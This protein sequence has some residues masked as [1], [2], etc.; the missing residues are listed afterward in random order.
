ML[1][2]GGASSGDEAGCLSAGSAENIWGGAEM[3]IGGEESGEDW[4]P[5]M[6]QRREWSSGGRRGNGEKM[7]RAR[8]NCGAPVPNRG[9]RRG[10]RESKGEEERGLWG[11]L[12]RG[13]WR[14]E[15][16]GMVKQ[17]RM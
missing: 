4:V 10:I 14:G 16:H 15:A 12:F 5:A 7:G 8:R 11:W 3:S 1:W 13:K 9:T 17:R 2:G 6:L